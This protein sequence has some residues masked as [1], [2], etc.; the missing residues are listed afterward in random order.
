MLKEVTSEVLDW[1]LSD[2]EDVVYEEYDEKN[3]YK[4]K[5]KVLDHIRKEYKDRK[6]IGVEDVS[7][8]IEEVLKKLKYDEVYESFKNYRERRNYGT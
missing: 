1:Y 7:D 4:V 5:E 8:I 2:M 6:T 3:V